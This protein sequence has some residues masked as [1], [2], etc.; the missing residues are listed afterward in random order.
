MKTAAIITIKEPEHMSA[1]GREAIG[2]WLAQCAANFAL[3]PDYSS[4]KHFRYL[5]G[6]G[7][8]K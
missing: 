2:L 1:K 8:K 5:C 3:D 4:V 7:S 6:N